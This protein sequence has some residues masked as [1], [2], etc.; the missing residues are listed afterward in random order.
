LTFRETEIHYSIWLYPQK[1]DN[2]FYII[3]FSILLHISCLYILSFIKPDILNSA[4]QSS[5]EFD[6][7]EPINIR[8]TDG[9]FPESLPN[10]EQAN[11]KIGAINIPKN[12]S[13]GI[14]TDNN[15]NSKSKILVPKNL[16]TPDIEAQK[17][18]FLSNLQPHERKKDLPPSISKKPQK[19]ETNGIE[20]FLPNSSP[21]Y[22]DQLRRD[23]HYQ[24]Q[25]EGDSGDIPV[26]GDDLVPKNGPKIVERF[27]IR[28]LSLYQFSQEFKEKFSGIWN[29]RERWVPPNSPLRPGD[30]VYYKLYIKGDGS[31]EKFEN[32]SQKKK[33]EKDFSAVDKMIAEVVTQV[34][35]M[36]V[37]PRFAHHLVTEIIS[38]QIVGTNRPVQYSFQ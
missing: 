24:H 3:L 30:T 33:P 37:P 32:L 35:P 29:S 25:I 13:G 16:F 2:L 8:F 26:I 7:N 1:Q 14:L 9:K 22:L 34:F 31:L 23:S 11:K 36:T 18:P 10:Y 21:S 6:P 17:N 27:A 4:N 5:T 19:I 38:I 12:H 20:A 15:P 28:D